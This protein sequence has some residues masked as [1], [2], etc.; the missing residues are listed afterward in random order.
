MRMFLVAAFLLTAIPAHADVVSKAP[1]GFTIST[2]GEVALPVDQ[3]WRRLVTP[4]SWWSDAHTYSGKAANV[5]LT[6]KAG[7]CWCEIWDGNEVEHARVVSLFKNQ[8]L[9]VEGAFGPLQEMAVSGAMTYT[10]APGKDA[11]HTKI[12]IT[13]TVTGSALSKLDEI[14]GP[15]DSVLVEQFQGLITIK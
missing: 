7:G 14:A 13:Y 12:T 11:K 15:V 3:A 5:R 10:L 2:S 4:K 1:D 8:M 6:E 9:R